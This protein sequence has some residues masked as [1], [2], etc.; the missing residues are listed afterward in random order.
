MLYRSDLNFEVFSKFKPEYLRCSF[1]G[2][3]DSKMIRT[4][5]SLIIGLIGKK[6]VRENINI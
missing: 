5:D 1:Y 3:H 2:N 4:D 6:R